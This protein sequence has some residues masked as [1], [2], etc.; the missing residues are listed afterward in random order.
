[1]QGSVWIVRISYRSFQSRDRLYGPWVFDEQRKA[2]LFV[3]DVFAP[4]LVKWMEYFPLILPE[5]QA[6]RRNSDRLRILQDH[7]RLSE[8]Q[9]LYETEREQRSKD[10]WTWKLTSQRCNP[11]AWEGQSLIGREFRHLQ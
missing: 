9:M 5:E 1:M 8:A 7:A 10:Y 2:R 6:K 4:P 3:Y 11:E